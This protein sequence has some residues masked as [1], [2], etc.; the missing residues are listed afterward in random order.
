M[1][2]KMGIDMSAEPENKKPPIGWPR[3]FA[4]TAKWF[5]M[6]TVSE[7]VLM[8]LL[9]G[10]HALWRIYIAGDYPLTLAYIIIG[11]CITVGGHF[12]ALIAASI[13]HQS[14]KIAFLYI[15]LPVLLG[16]ILWI[17]IDSG[18]S[19]MMACSMMT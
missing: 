19:S 14:G 18:I 7:A 1:V 16:I 13:I 12:I 3:A 8:L 6:T 5:L 17:W 11:A 9:F 10:G 4:L 2:T 15:G